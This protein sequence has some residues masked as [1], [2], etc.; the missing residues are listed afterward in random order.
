MLRN[1]ALIIIAAISFILL[2]IG[3]SCAVLAFKQL[4]ICEV[5]SS[6]VYCYGPCINKKPCG[7]WRC[8]ARDY[9]DEMIEKIH[10]TCK[11]KK[12]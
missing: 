7:K 5:S 2:S 11:R 10:K 9:N 6:S 4:P 1:S 8:F 12:P 3:G